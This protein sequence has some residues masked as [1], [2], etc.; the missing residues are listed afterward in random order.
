MFRVVFPLGLVCLS[1]ICAAPAW[2]QDAPA[3]TNPFTDPAPAAAPAATAPATAPAPAPIAAPAPATALEVL[4][5]QNLLP[6]TD[7]TKYYAKQSATV[8]YADKQA[9]M[10]YFM[11]APVVTAP[12]GTQFPVVLVLS[13][14]NG[15]AH[16]GRFLI[17][18]S[19]RGAY[20]AYVVVPALPEGT[21]WAEPGKPRPTHMLSA[22]VEIIK[23]LQAL[24]SAIDAKRIYVIGC[25]PGGNG[26]YG[27]AQNY[28]DMFAAAVPIGAIWNAREISNM[29]KVPVAAFHG[30]DDT[31]VPLA[32][33]NDTITMLQHSGGTAFFTKYDHMGHD[34]SS[35]RI[36][37]ELLWKWLF[38][39]K[40]P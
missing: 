17:T 10:T 21:R 20:P 13:D 5:P 23:Q 35:D 11:F 15:E 1:L 39:Q 4:T 31:K 25:G 30:A 22:A 3:K 26:A 40:K 18:E 28:S 27:A 9:Q 24:N 14:A 33:S 36:Y 32:D 7:F 19:V 37:N 34:C 8:P 16:A 38:A 6:L 29:T 2:A 12:P